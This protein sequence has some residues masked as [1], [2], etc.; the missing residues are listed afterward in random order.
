[1]EDIAVRVD[2]FRQRLVWQG[3]TR[4]AVVWS[5]PQAF[6][7]ESYWARKPTSK[8]LALEMLIAIN[9][10]SLGIMPWIDRP[11]DPLMRPGISPLAEAVPTLA[12]YILGRKSVSSR[13]VVSG[14][15][16]VD[17]TTWTNG[18]STLLIALNLN[19]APVQAQV[20]INLPHSK[21]KVV[22]ENG[23][24]VARNSSKVVDLRFQPLSS[25]AVVF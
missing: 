4:E 20:L 1:M 19:D 21:P 22:F 12:P 10:G 9:H 11:Q 24:A 6:G 13:P 23:V 15:K 5:A 7:P 18:D 8:E 16:R 2:A 25:I 17:V 14:A 3:R